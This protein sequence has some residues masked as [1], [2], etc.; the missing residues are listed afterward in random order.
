MDHLIIGIET[1]TK[2][3]MVLNF[4]DMMIMIDQQ[5]L[6]M[7]TFESISNPKQLRSQ[8]KAFTEPISMQ[9]A[10]NRAVT[11]L[12]AKYKKTNLL[13]VVNKNCKHLTMSQWNHLLKLL[14]EFKELFD[15]TL[16]DWKTEPVKFQLKPGTALYHGRAFLI[17]HIHLET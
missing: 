11:I 3:G 2:L 8:F 12:D 9:E 6:P 16:G 7:R 14:I 4:D 10:T 1:M 13:Q 17:P 15:G 5:K